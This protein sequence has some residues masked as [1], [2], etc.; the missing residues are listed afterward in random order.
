MKLFRPGQALRTAA[1]G[2]LLF[3]ALFAFIGCDDSGGGDSSI[4]TTD[5]ASLNTEISP[6]RVAIGNLAFATVRFNDAEF[7][8][9]DSQGLT[10]KLLVPEEMSFKNGSATLTLSQGAVAVTPIAIA[11]APD[12]LVLSLLADSS[13]EP[14]PGAESSRG[15]IFYIFSLPAALLDDDTEGVLEMTFSV[16]SLPARSVV[17]TDIDRGAV[18][19]FDP[20][21]SDFDG[22]QATEFVI[23]DGRVITE[24]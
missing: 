20:A 23:D 17:Y 5:S 6:D 19:S 11:P 10:I 1:A 16:D 13:V 8:D 22:E 4:G 7:D 24:E 18:S 2:I 9:L 15:F 14:N 12:A 21:S 3:A